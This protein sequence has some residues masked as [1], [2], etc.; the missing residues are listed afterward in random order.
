MRVEYAT[1]LRAMGNTGME[2]FIEKI[3][4]CISP[5]TDSTTAFCKRN[6]V[7][8]VAFRALKMIAHSI[9]KDVCNIEIEHIFAEHY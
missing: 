5:D 1:V 6:S 2:M 3:H 4:S 9:P 7:R 8:V